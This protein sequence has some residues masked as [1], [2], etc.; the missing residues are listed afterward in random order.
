MRI[1]YLIPTIAFGLIEMILTAYIMNVGLR[2]VFIL[3]PMLWTWNLIG[4]GI[5]LVLTV[6]GNK[7][8]KDGYMEASNY[9]NLNRIGK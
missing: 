4:F 7:P 5:F 3:V 8:Q 9:A 6:R 1:V 2:N